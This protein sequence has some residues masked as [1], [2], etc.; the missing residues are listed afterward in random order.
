MC[1]DWKATKETLISLFISMCGLLF[2]FSLLYK[3][4]DQPDIQPMH[5]LFILNSML[6]FKNNIELNYADIMS[7]TVQKII[8]AHKKILPVTIFD[9]VFDCGSKMFCISAL[10]SILIGVFSNYSN[11]YH[12]LCMQETKKHF[13]TIGTTI[14]ISFF[15]GI[16]SCIITFIAVIAC[17]TTCIYFR[18]N[19]DN[20]ILPIIAS[21]SDYT[22]TISLSYFSSHI[23]VFVAEMY[24]TLFNAPLQYPSSFSNRLFIINCTFILAISF[25]LF[26]AHIKTRSRIM[27]RL[28]RIWSLV[29]SFGIIVVTGSFINYISTCSKELSILISLFNGL[30]GS[31]ALVYIG[32]ITTYTHNPIKERRKN[33]ISLESQELHEENPRS[34]QT[35]FSLLF[36]S[37][38]LSLLSSFSVIFFF[39]SISSVYLYIIGVLII[40]E[41]FILYNFV[42]LFVSTLSYLGIAL[43]CHAVPILNASSDLIGTIVLTGTIYLIMHLPVSS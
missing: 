14:S 22:T 31:I 15:T 33:I 28:F 12:L 18:C 39:P 32:K 38:F 7:S 16:C 3:V 34:I 26:G 35:L 20:I 11:I 23:Y 10:A 24:P 13:I 9:Y 40:I 29:V 4:I 17:I 1:I 5:Y 21:F 30:S 41:T 42:N 19:P 43:E 25:A 2:M 36:V 27:P 37:V 8:S 6:S